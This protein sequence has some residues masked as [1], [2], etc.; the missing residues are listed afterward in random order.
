MQV[1]L[2]GVETKGEE[3]KRSG[4]GGEEENRREGRRRIGG[5]GR[6]KSRR[7]GKGEE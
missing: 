4:S 6:E 5:K 1:G 2:R 7:S 3:D